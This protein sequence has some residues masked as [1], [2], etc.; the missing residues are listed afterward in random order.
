MSPW[1]AELLT[2]EVQCGFAIE[3]FTPMGVS[4]EHRYDYTYTGVRMLILLNVG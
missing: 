1:R 4:R 2:D 3:M